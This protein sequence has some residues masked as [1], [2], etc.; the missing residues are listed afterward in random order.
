MKIDMIEKLGHQVVTEAGIVRQ[1][2]AIASSIDG[3]QS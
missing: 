2:V 1:A 3:A